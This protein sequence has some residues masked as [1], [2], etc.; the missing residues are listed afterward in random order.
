MATA[1]A[2]SHLAPVVTATPAGQAAGGL[3]LVAMVV[4]A[5]FLTAG[6]SAARGL[7]AVLA[8]FVRL[9][10]AMTSAVVLLV[11]VVVMAAALLIHR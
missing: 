8:Q 7:A 3:A 2:V 5:I 4:I 6:A 11:V 10:T 1:R 9:A